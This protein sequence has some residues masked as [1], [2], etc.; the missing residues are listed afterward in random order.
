[1]SRQS[2]DFYPALR[3]HRRRLGWS[4]EDLARRIGVRRQAVY[5][6]ESGRYLPNTA[7]ALELARLFGC[8]VEELFAA[9]PPAVSVAP[10]LVAQ[11]LLLMGCDPALPVLGAHVSLLLPGLRAHCL[12]ASSGRA[13]N[14]LFQGGSHVAA[15]HFH[16]EGADQANVA[17]VAKLVGTSGRACRVLTFADNEE[18]LMVAPGNPLDIRGVEDLAR[19]G[20]RFVNREP[21]AALR[22]LLEA[23]LAE[24]G[25]SESAVAD[26]DQVVF[27]HEEGAGRVACGTAD[28]ALGP[29]TTAASF[30]LSFI[31]LAITRCDLVVPESLLTHLGVAALL[32][33]LQ[34]ARLRRELARLPGCDSART[35]VEIARIG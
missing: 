29:R 18:G 32:D 21:G 30:G 23:H 35:G 26:P 22:R 4:Q 2:S 1:M 24:A 13:L 16:N 10:A 7:V 17:A 9:P 5:D 33:A 34:S 14:M 25:V 3:E 15:T 31:P 11:R 19:P 20:L 6:M 8:P 28:A 27:S 12:F